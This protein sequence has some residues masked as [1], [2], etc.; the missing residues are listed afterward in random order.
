MEES[1]TSWDNFENENNEKTAI[2][3][4]EN[5]EYLIELFNNSISYEE[6][7]NE[8]K[9]AKYLLVP[10]YHNYI[11][12]SS[13]YTRLFNAGGKLI[14]P[15]QLIDKRKLIL[16][17][18]LIFDYEPIFGLRWKMF[19]RYKSE[20]NSDE[21]LIYELLLIKFRH[22]GYS[23][24]FLSYNDMY[25]ELGIKETRAR[26]IIKKFSEIGIITTRV[27]LEQFN[28]N[29]SKRTYYKLIPRKIILFQ[30]HIIN[31]EFLDEV[32]E[33]LETYLEPVLKKRES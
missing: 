12:K 31:N 33:E 27:K 24:F 5:S 23:E 3:K 4:S 32:K 26:T 29:P 8:N 11:D 19:K 6:N 13:N 25:K 14:I 7:F 2:L 20:F 10:L 16:K 22:F 1:L 17:E 21:R 15:K 18:Y 9:D 28:N 30:N